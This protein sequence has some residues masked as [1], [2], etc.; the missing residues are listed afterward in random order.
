MA[1][2]IFIVKTTP[3]SIYSLKWWKTSDLLDSFLNRITGVTRQ[4][5]M[6]ITD[7]EVFVGVVQGHEGTAHYN[8]LHLI[9][10]MTQLLQL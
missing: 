10:G 4:G 2:L 6:K 5:V 8:V 3:L 1:V 7:E 9:D